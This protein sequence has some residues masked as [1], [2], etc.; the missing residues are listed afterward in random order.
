[1]HPSNSCNSV[2][3]QL[4]Q[5]SSVVT[6]RFERGRVFI[7][8]NEAKELESIEKLKQIKAIGAVFIGTSGLTSLN[9]AS[10]RKMVEYIVIIDSS[11]LVKLFWG[12][13]GDVIKNSSD[14]EECLINLERHIVQRINDYT[15]FEENYLD[16][17]CSA[18]KS[19]T[20]WLYDD[21]R[22]KKIWEIFKNGHFV[23]LQADLADGA[24]TQKIQKIFKRFE[25]QVDTI[26]L[27]NIHEYFDHSG[28]TDYEKSLE[29]LL[30]T[31]TIIVDTIERAFKVTKIFLY[32]KTDMCLLDHIDLPLEHACH[33]PETLQQQVRQ[34]DGEPV[35][36]LYPII[37]IARRL[38]LQG[39]TSLLFYHYGLYKNYFTKKELKEA[40]KKTQ[41][42]L[43]S[44]ISEKKSY[45]DKFKIIGANLEKT[46]VQNL[47]PTKY[48]PTAVAN[49]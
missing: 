48:P 12:K 35:K 10:V 19:S 13:I 1:M 33:L 32:Y 42:A 39:D 11:P 8:T 2:V 23:F 26:Y 5:I 30:S 37:D 45:P 4:N 36:T 25:L 38:Q 9:L 43:E 29:S 40:E 47:Y 6:R 7:T 41:E 49:K 24:T 31:K 21:I 22:F 44:L 34:R 27:S 3:F 17:F 16:I 46:A 18:L 20:S 15:S 14:R 28:Y